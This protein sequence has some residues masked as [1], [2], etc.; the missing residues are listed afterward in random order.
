MWSESQDV[1]AWCPA[2][3]TKCVGVMRIKWV[4]SCVPHDDDIVMHLTARADVV[5]R[6][7]RGR[8]AYHMSG[9]RTG[10]SAGSL[11]GMMAYTFRFFALPN[12]KR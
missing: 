7:V 1:G 10:C 12:I 5:R 2:H 3:G 9:G 6:G 8:R 11:R 4:V